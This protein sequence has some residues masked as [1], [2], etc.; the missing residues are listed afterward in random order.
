MNQS[1]MGRKLEHARILFH[2]LLRLHSSTRVATHL[3]ILSDHFV[4]DTTK[5]RSGATIS[6][7]LIGR[8]KALQCLPRGVDAR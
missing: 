6:S 8:L 2:K 7:E 4:D 5:I 1:T 3:S